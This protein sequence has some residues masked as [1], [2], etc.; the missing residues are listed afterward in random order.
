[1]LKRL[2]MEEETEAFEE[3][4]KNNLQETFVSNTFQ[5][6]EYYHMTC[7]TCLEEKE[8]FHEKTLIN[9]MPVISSTKS[10]KLSNAKEPVKNYTVY[11]LLDEYYAYNKQD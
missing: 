8:G 9:L 4:I 3:Y 7:G 1:M 10:D 11:D 5:F 2:N 6:L